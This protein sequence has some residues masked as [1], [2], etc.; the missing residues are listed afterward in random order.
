MNG[1]RVGLS[2]PLITVP[3]VPII[4][5]HYLYARGLQPGNG[6]VIYGL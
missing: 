4:G 3:L 1:V 2:V 5:A 6:A